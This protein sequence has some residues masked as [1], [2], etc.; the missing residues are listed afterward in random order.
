MGNSE[1]HDIIYLQWNE[2][3]D[4]KFDDQIRKHLYHLV[5]AGELVFLNNAQII[6]LKKNLYDLSNILCFVEKN[7]KKLLCSNFPSIPVGNYTVSLL[8]KTVIKCSRKGKK[9]YGRLT[10]PHFATRC[11]TLAQISWLAYKKI[12]VH[13]GRLSASRDRKRA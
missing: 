2:V 9:F 12:Y 10:L 5:K 11:G 13:G 3:N 4:P 8:L 7:W 6:C 1:P